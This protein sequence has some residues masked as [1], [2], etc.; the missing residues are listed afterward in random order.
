MSVQLEPDCLDLV[1]VNV[2]SGSKC[3]LRASALPSPKP[4]YIGPGTILLSLGT[5]Y[6]DY[7]ATLARTLLFNTTKVRCFFMFTR[8]NIF[9]GFS[10]GKTGSVSVRFRDIGVRY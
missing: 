6:Q 3:D 10:S 1:F 2:Q 5:K 9:N 7:T 4:L 8:K